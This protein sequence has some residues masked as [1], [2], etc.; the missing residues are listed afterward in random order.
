MNVY[1]LR[2][3]CLNDLNNALELVSN[4]H[5]FWVNLE[6]ISPNFPDVEIVLVSDKTLQE[7]RDILMGEEDLHVVTETINEIRKYTGER[8]YK[9]Y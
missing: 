8:Y 9:D 4:E 7:L 5:T 2:A 3:E 6:K 1:K